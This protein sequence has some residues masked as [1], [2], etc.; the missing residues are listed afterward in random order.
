MNE[1]VK[2]QAVFVVESKGRKF[3]DVV[4]QR[5]GFISVL[6]LTTSVRKCFI[7][8]P[9]QDQSATLVAKT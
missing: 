6:L 3:T 8:R 4:I 1:P 2:P 9:G 5:N 7:G